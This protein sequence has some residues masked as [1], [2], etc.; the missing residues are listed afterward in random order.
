MTEKDDRDN[1]MVEL[2]E[3]LAVLETGDIGDD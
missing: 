3:K 2:Q 1:I